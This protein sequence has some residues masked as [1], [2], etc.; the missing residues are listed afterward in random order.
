MQLHLGHRPNHLM[1]WHLADE[2]G[3]LT[4]VLNVLSAEVGVD[5]DNVHVDTAKVQKKRARELEEK[6][7][8]ED[9]KTFRN[10]MGNALTDLASSSRLLAKTRK[11]EAIQTLIA[12]KTTARSMEEDKMV[13]YYERSLDVDAESDKYELYHQ[14]AVTHQKRIDQYSKDIEEL[15]AKLFSDK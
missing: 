14:L 8:R 1:L 2:M 11:V 6:E 4:N 12:Q 13:K 7:E 10:N 3:V 5:G 15:E 9:R